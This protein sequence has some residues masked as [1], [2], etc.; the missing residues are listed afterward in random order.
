MRISLALSFNRKVS[1]EVVEKLSELLLVLKCI[2]ADNFV[3]YKR[4]SGFWFFL[5]DYVNACL[6]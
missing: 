4:G 2:N 3:G 5:A 6:T 1:G